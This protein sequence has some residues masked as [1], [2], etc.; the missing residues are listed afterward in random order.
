MKIPSF[1][2]AFFLSIFCYSQD[3]TLSS[4]DWRLDFIEIDGQAYYP[5]VNEELYQVPLIFENNGLLFKSFVC[6]QGEGEL[7]FD[8]PY[9]SFNFVDGINFTLPE[10]QNTENSDFE[11]LYFGFF[12]NE[13]IETFDYEIYIIDFPE[14][15]NLIITSASGNFA[16]YNDFTLSNQEFSDSNILIFP[17]PVEDELFISTSSDIGAFSITIYNISGNSILTT[18]YNNGDESINVENFKKGIYFISIKDEFG[19][20]SIKRMIKN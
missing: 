20:T 17:N 11:E 10:C 13:I 4:V 19:N 6:K 2:F 16:Y 9:L 14:A 15:Y 3:G 8:D 5:P 18:S 1:I 7:V 12:L